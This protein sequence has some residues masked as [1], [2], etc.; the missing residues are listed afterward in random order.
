V[1]DVYPVPR[2]KAQ[3]SLLDEAR[4]LFSAMVYGYTFVYTP[5]DK[6]RRVEERF[7]LAP[8]AEIQW[9][10]PRMEIRE[11]DIDEARLS[12]R[13]CYTM[14]ENEIRRR[15]SWESNSAFLSTGAGAASAFMGP[16]GKRAALANAI[17]DAIRNHLNVRVLNKPR[18]IRG[19][20]VL[21]ED[22]Q[23]VVRAGAYQTQAKVR[24]EVREVV[25]YR[26]F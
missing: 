8:V 2:E 24:L 11:T 16:S 4:I 1:G 20:V 13:F 10:S 6:S 17:K 25:S 3:K 19:E 21:W 22:P 12:A 15:S 18:E 14:S 5:G 7:E 9:G 23:T 26:I